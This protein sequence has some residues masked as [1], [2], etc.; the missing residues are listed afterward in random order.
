MRHAV[1]R[2]GEIGKPG[3]VVIADPILGRADPIVLPDRVLGTRPHLLD[4][5][6]G[7]T[8]LHT[9]EIAELTTIRLPERDHLEAADLG[10]IV[11]APHVL[12]ANVLRDR[13]DA[14]V[15]A[16]P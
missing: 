15:V 13:T 10:M 14:E 12:D 3:R 8:E 2:A 5:L 7:L 9:V 16:A 1:A 6:D 11:V 4:R